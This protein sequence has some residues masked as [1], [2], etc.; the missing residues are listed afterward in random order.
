M[1]ELTAD[2]LAQRAFD[3]GLIDGPQLS[4]LRSELGP[5]PGSTEDFRRVASRR[6]LLTNFQIDRLIKGE[7]TGYFYGDYKVL[8][9]ATWGWGVE[10]GTH[11]LRIVFGGVFERFPK[12]LLLLG[13]CGESL[14]FMLWRLDSRAKAL[15]G[16][17]M[18]KDVS[19]FI[20]D[21]IAVTISGM[22][23][24]EPVDCSIAA[25]GRDR[26]MFSADFPF[27]SIHEA[28]SFMDDVTMAEDLRE[29][30]AWRNAAK[31]LNIKDV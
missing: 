22:Y 28:G 29:D 18:K 30:V 4:A 5:M 8:M 20:I 7:R 16:V 17:K 25:L 11:A 13:H 14:P 12:A 24:R 21:N 19:Q 10:T 3:F 15:Y 2:K 31:I 26:V 9:R 6:E 1:A 27:E 23:S